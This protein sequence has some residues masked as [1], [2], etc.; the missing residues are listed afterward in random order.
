M[1]KLWNELAGITWSI[2]GAAL[3]IITLEGATKELAL[4]LTLIGVSVHLITTLFT[5]EDK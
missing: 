1:K 3:V 2:I 5:K 4:K